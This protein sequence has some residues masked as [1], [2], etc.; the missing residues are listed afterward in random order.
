MLPAA[1]LAIELGRVTES[2]LPSKL[3]APPKRPPGFHVAPLTVPSLPLP[4]AS[5]ANQIEAAKKKSEKK[6]EE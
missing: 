4:V 5:P 3:R 2:L 6:K 1:L